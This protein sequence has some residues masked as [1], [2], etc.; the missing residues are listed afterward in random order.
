M[1][2]FF[3][4]KHLHISK[5]FISNTIRDN[6]A[7]LP[8]LKDLNT[9][10]IHYTEIKAYQ[11]MLHQFLGTQNTAKITNATILSIMYLLQNAGESLQTIQVSK[12]KK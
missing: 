9:T 8:E 11:Y 7:D 2:I 6:I 10:C 12:I 4:Q 3:I 1:Q 5:S